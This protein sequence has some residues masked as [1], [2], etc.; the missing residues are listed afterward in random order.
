MSLCLS[1][2]EP[3]PSRLLEISPSIILTRYSNISRWLGTNTNKAYTDHAR[4]KDHVAGMDGGLE[5]KLN[6]GGKHLVSTSLLLVS[7]FIPFLS[8][9]PWLAIVLVGLFTTAKSWTMM[10]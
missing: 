1:F 6:E 10:E 2:C 5:A 8:L 4:L 7:L 3:L 9:R